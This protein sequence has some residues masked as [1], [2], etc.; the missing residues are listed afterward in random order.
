[1]LPLESRTGVLLFMME[2]HEFEADMSLVG[3]TVCPVEEY[4]SFGE[5][6]CVLLLLIVFP[7]ALTGLTCLLMR[8]IDGSGLS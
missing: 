8:L 5:G 7:Q 6:F 4:S 1:M 3:A 2:A